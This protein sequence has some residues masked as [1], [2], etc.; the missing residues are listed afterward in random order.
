MTSDRQDIVDTCVRYG[1]HADL[2]EWDRMAELFTERVDLDTRTMPGGARVTVGR[3]DM[4]D[5]WAGLFAT[6]G[7]TQHIM[8]NH[9]VQ[10]DGDTAECVAQFHAQHLAPVPAGD[11]TLVIAGNYR[12]GLVRKAE[13]W[14]IHAL[15]ISQT[16][17]SGNLAVL[18]GG[19][20]AGDSA[21]AVAR[22][23]LESLD[24]GDVDAAIA[25]LAHDVVQD[26][27]YSP[28]GYPKQL[29]GADTLRGLWTGLT[30]ATQSMKFT[31]VEVR[32]FTDPEWVFV[33]FTADLV[34]PSG[35][36]YS[37]HYFTFF[38]VVDGLIRV[39]REVYDPLVFAT[40]V[41]DEDRAAMF[42]TG[43]A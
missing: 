35:A 41:S 32:R 38:H 22:R 13:G 10:I 17:S 11:D 2:R 39:Y 19:R 36:L 37:N 15:T 33:E 31:I 21:P 18:G 1:W 29:H 5:G 24:A 27:P 3:A 4:I 23:F 12:F 20:P 7:P 26:M 6:L 34:Q 25:C 40:D 16:W 28:P 30:E 9:L 43:Q 42:R 8:A 14:R